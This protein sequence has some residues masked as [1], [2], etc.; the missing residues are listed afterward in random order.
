MDQRPS[1]GLV[2]GEHGSGASTEK[3]TKFSQATED[4]NDGVRGLIQV[5]E[6]LHM[7]QQQPQGPAIHWERFLPVRSIKV[8]L[9]EDDDSTRHVVSALLR[10][11]SYEGN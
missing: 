11:C 1:N 10:N 9:V 5:H 8:L 7:S 3:E 6:S 2:N 4:G